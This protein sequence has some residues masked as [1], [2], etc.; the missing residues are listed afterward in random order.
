MEGF[1]LFYSAKNNQPE[2]SRRLAECIG[3]EFIKAGFKPNHYHA[4]DIPGERRNEVDPKRAI[5]KRDL[6]VNANTNM[7]SVLIECGCLVSPE[8]EK[9]LSQ[10]ET[11]QK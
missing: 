7:P 5:Y 4:K 8:E 3:D 10:K 11:R 2:Q 9:R 1:S 6:Y